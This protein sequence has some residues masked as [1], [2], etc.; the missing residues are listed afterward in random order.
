MGKPER[1]KPKVIEDFASKLTK[2]Q[3]SKNAQTEPIV[4][5]GEGTSKERA[6]FSL[7]QEIKGNHDA[8]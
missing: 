3:H 5:Q 7:L 1:E 6:T 8:L 2:S 4:E